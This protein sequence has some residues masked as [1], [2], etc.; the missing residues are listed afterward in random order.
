MTV[1]LCKPLTLQRSLNY[2][3]QDTT[4]I[5]LIPVDF[6]LILF[7]IHSHDH[8]QTYCLPTYVLEKDVT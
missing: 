2:N 5:E 4:S 7:T 8:A 3:V 6:L 1:T